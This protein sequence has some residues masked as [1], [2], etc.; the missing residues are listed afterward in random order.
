ME[1]DET[2]WVQ[3]QWNEMTW[4]QWHEMTLNQMNEIE[5]NEMQWNGIYKKPNDTKWMACEL[6]EMTLNEMECKW[7]EWYEI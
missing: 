6:H 2:Q 4:L 7:N 3:F 5:W 1:C